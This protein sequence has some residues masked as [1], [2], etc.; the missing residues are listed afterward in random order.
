MRKRG[1]YIFI[2]FMVMMLM[3]AGC[4]AASDN[5]AAADT[6]SSDAAA[7]TE[8]AEA[9]AAAPLAGADEQFSASVADSGQTAAAADTS[10]TSSSVLET[11]KASETAAG[12]TGSAETADGLNKKLIYKANL[13]MEVKDYG[14]AQTEVRNLITL[15]NGYIVEFNEN[16]S[17]YEQGGTFVLKVPA[18]GF[19]SF[20]NKLEQ[21]EHKSIQR[22][23]Q[24]QDVSEEY[25][26]LG[27]RLKAKQLMEAQYVEFMKKATKSADLVA[28]ANQLGAIQEEIETLKGRMRYIDQ[29]VSF[30]TI[31]LRLYQPEVKTAAVDDEKEAKPL[32]ERVS[33]ALNGSLNAISVTF[34]WLVI[35]LAGAL[36][37]LILA[38]I[39]LAIFLAI[40]R[41]SKPRGNRLERFAPAEEGSLT[42]PLSPS[43]PAPH[44]V[45]GKT[46]DVEPEPEDTGK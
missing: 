18:G 15:A 28:F 13:A 26:D 1:L 20:L 37:I 40:R 30:S 23:I 19:S 21:V 31:E 44:K 16:T 2:G 22:S 34:Q 14:A 45:A 43:G 33:D 32:S 11:E 35:V 6:G 12:F 9:P 10:K 42:A 25:V 8:A 3:L 27:S 46:D 5:D 39:V 24:G 41:K 38:G 17:E 4:G 7:M 36:P 29:N